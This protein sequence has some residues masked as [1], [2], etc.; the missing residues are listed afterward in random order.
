LN[1]GF[2]TASL[3]SE[4][5]G[6]AD[7]AA[8]LGARLWEALD[9][10]GLAG[11]Q[12]AVLRRVDEHQAIFAQVSNNGAARVPATLA[13]VAVFKAGFVVWELKLGAPHAHGGGGILTLSKSCKVAQVPL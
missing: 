3:A 13:S 1:T 11:C 2:P 4:E 10:R 5:H 12:G 7:E 6:I 8:R 9:A